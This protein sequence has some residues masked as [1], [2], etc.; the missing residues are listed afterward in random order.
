[1][2]A[3][4]SVLLSKPL[5]YDS[6]P[7]CPACREGTIQAL[8]RL[9]RPIMA[10]VIGA[11][12]DPLGIKGRMFARQATQRRVG[13][14][15]PRPTHN[16]SDMSARIGASS[17]RPPSAAWSPSPPPSAPREGAESSQLAGLQVG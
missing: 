13:L 6:T 10:A 5:L 15:S 17:P 9:Y 3:A 8:G 14:S 12:P 2:R 4:C 11:S 16:T 7:I 1:M